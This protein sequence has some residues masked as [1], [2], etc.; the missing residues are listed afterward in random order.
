MWLLRLSCDCHAVFMWLSCHC[1][2]TSTMHFFDR[3]YLWDI[4][5]IREEVPPSSNEPIPPDTSSCISDSWE[6][7]AM[8]CGLTDMLV[9][10]VTSCDIM[11]L[12]WF[13]WEMMVPTQSFLRV[14]YCLGYMACFHPLVP[15]WCPTSHH[16]L[17]TLP[18]VLWSAGVWTDR[19][20]HSCP[21]C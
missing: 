19:R 2:V 5:R 4:R 17:C 11:W 14:F 20:L 3:L 10:H 1:E 8:P 12:T 6:S 9:G 16:F 21:L 18:C 15:Q 13:S 7:P